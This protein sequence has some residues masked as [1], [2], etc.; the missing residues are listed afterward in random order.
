MYIL[1]ASFTIAGLLGASWLPVFRDAEGYI[2]PEFCLLLSFI[3]ALLFAA[4][5]WRTSLRRAA[6][7]FALFLAGQGLSLQLIDA[8]TAIHYQHYRVIQGF[9]T[10]RDAVLVALLVLQ[11]LA[12]IVGSR[13]IISQVIAW[14]MSH[15]GFTRL[16]I[17][18][19]ILVSL[20]VFP[21]RELHLFA[22]ELLISGIIVTTQLACLVLGLMA[23]PSDTL[24]QW[25]TRINGFIGGSPPTQAVSPATGSNR[26][27]IACAAWVIAIST[28]L[29]FFSYERH[30]HIPDEVAYIY[31]ANYFA[32]GRLSTPVPP[33]PEAADTYLIDCDTERCVS[34]V[35]PGW[36]AVL[37]IGAFAGIA[38]LVNPLLAGINVVL[39]FMLL[40]Q[41]YDRYTAR[42]GVLLASA[43]PWYLLMSM[44]FMT[45]TFSLTCTL[46]AALSV[47]RMHRRHK[48]IW[49]VPGGIAIGLLSLTRPLEGLM[50]A[51]VLGLA[52]LFIPGQRFRLAPV[53]VLGLSSLVIGATV[54]P[55]NEAL[56]GDPF[57]FPI[58]AYTDKALGPG[59]NSLGFGPDKGVAWGGLDPFPGHGLPD[60]LVNSALN[61]SAINIEM[62]GWSIGSLLP[63][64]LWLA[65]R[66]IRRIETIDRWMLFFIFVIFGYQ[67]LYWFSGGP[68]F[69]ARYYYLAVIPLIALTIQALK[70]LGQTVPAGTNPSSQVSAAVLAGMLVLSTGAL[71]N[72][73]PWRAIDKYHHY[74][75]MRPDIRTLLAEKDFGAALLLIK[76][77][78]HPDLNS[79]I[80]YSPID[81]Y[82]DKPVIAWDR[83][84]VV[85]QRLFAAY[86]DRK[87][88]LIDGP[89]LTGAGYRVTAGPINPSALAQ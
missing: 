32:E 41:L 21:S 88:W 70:S 79:A 77:E 69:G 81:P 42:L 10:S 28:A 68:D 14:I 29:A 53:V 2:N 20:S 84:S 1:F 27:V 18:F 57:T 63:I 16:L 65:S 80:V 59:T 17:V 73:L 66:S 24:S 35:P 7:W 6:G 60:V 44:N 13:S 38:W 51:T 52:A 30:P 5:A 76:G 62:F 71:A 72:F 15:L 46:V 75:G 8:G 47:V 54:L 89:S 39:I 50:V 87:I 56:T 19:V 22:L 25:G 11:V 31:H 45:H 85:R 49:G 37:A 74:R 3:V 26:L 33:V 43:S 58:M 55:Y 9:G 83:D 86:P 82:A 64:V 61:L 36:P 23:I 40:R 48:S 4:A 67:S 12:V 78:S 34:P